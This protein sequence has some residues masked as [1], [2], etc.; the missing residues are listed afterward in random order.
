[1]K[2]ALHF[3]IWLRDACIGQQEGL[4]AAYVLPSIGG[5]DEHI[6]GCDPTNTGVEGGWRP[7]NWDDYW[8]EPGVRIETRNGNHKNRFVCDFK[9]MKAGTD[10]GIPVSFEQRNSNSLW[11]T[12]QPPKVYWEG[13]DVW[14]NILNQRGWLDDYG[15][16][17][18]P[19]WLTKPRH[20]HVWRELEMEPDA[21]PWDEETQHYS[22][23]SRIAEH[24]VVWHVDD[25]HTVK[26]HDTRSGRVMR[27]HLCRYK[28]RFLVD[29]WGAG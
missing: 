27:E 15:W 16:L 13:G 17:R 9:P 5:Y 22:P 12:E 2:K 26:G 18:L 11:K 6:S 4:Q 28:R 24:V 19:D 29:A 3:D 7:A 23:I 10:W 14:Q 21:H 25:L 1:M 20:N 8:N